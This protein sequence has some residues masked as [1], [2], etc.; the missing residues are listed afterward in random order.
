MVNE[1]TAADNGTGD[2]IF[3]L[4][5]VADAD[6]LTTPSLRRM[7]YRALRYAKIGW[8]KDPSDLS[9]VKLTW[10]NELS[11]L[12][13][14]YCRMSA[15][16]HGYDLPNCNRGGAQAAI[17]SSGEAV[18]VFPAPVS[19]RDAVTSGAW[20]GAGAGDFE[21]TELYTVEYR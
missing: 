2:A 12:S 3:V 4:Q 18:I 14:P 21:N 13:I 15:G 7:G 8:A 1:I 17:F 20:L 6:D 16:V 19:E 5:E 10:L 9:S 11:G